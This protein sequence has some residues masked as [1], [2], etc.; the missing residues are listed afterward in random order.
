MAL[1]HSA[2][3]I[4]HF[5]GQSW[6]SYGQNWWLTIRNVHRTP[7][8]SFWHLH[9]EGHEMD[10]FS[11]HKRDS[12]VYTS[13]L[14]QGIHGSKGDSTGHSRHSPLL[15]STWLLY[16]LISSQ[17]TETSTCVCLLRATESSSI[18]IGS[19]LIG[20]WLSEVSF[21]V[22][23]SISASNSHFNRSTF[24]VFVLYFF[25][26]PPHPILW[27]NI[28]YHLA[29]Q[30]KTSSTSQCHRQVIHCHHGQK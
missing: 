22:H 11:I 28:R 16:I 19:T 27:R 3:S 9:L 1:R 20:S 17:S 13:S 14:Q 6:D 18:I 23:T 21:T 24:L 25:I 12:H 15:K 8:N 7:T 4:I 30:V 29:P 2:L 5:T 10:S 26:L